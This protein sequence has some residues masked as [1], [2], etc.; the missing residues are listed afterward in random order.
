MA[1]F[2]RTQPSPQVK[3]PPYT[4]GKFRPHVR[5]DFNECCAY[6]LMPELWAGGENNFELDHFRPKHVFPNLRMDFHNL[7]WS[8][9][10]CNGNKWNHW[11]SE[12]LQKQGTGFVDFCR[13]DF[14]DHFRL[15]L[16]GLWIPQ[17]P[18][19]DYT[20]QILKLNRSHLVKLRRRVRWHP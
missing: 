10:V 3:G 14:H 20:E 15:S 6:C 4:Y 5:R 11:P 19:A 18:S 8:C 9:R 12:R 16:G 2:V 17:T 7:Y 13:D 1:R